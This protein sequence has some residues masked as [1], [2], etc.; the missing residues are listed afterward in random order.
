MAQ[1]AVKR[2][3]LER[4]RDGRASNGTTALDLRTPTPQ[5]SSDTSDH[6]VSSQ[7]EVEKPSP[8]PKSRRQSGQNSAGLVSSYNASLFDLQLNELLAEVRP[9]QQKR[10]PVIDETLRSLKTLIER[11]SPRDECSVC[12]VLSI[13]HVATT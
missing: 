9:D 8:R 5:P 1:H 2:R 6:E 7:S 10:M 11:I 4:D 13:M 3:K 12:F